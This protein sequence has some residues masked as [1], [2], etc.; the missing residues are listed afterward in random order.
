M[1]TIIRQVLITLFGVT[2]LGLMVAILM[3]MRGVPDDLTIT[4]SGLSGLSEP[5]GS[6]PA[7]V[8]DS[9]LLW[10]ET[11]IYAENSGDVNGDVKAIDLELNEGEGIRLYSVL[12]AI[13]VQQTGP[14]QGQMNAVLSLDPNIGVDSLSSSPYWLLIN[15]ETM[16]QVVDFIHSAVDMATA[17]GTVHNAYTEF[18]DFSATPIDIFVPELM[19]AMRT[20]TDS[21]S[22]A[23]VRIYYKKLRP[24]P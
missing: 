8:E 16:P 17:V 18:H 20:D 2:V 22:V 15:T 7:F 9:Q 10:K 12:W 6:P 13:R 23:G 11:S 19:L 14:T 21:K 3:T 5:Q 4:V 24:A 1:N